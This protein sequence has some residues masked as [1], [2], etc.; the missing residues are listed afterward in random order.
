MENKNEIVLF[1]HEEFGEVRTLMI[2]GEPWFVGKDVAH[3]LK[4]KNTKDAIS[5]HI[6]EE[7]KRIIQRSENTTFEIPPRGLTIINES[8]LYSQR[9]QQEPNAAQLHQQFAAN[10]CR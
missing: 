8:G 5:V 3:I 6:D 1:K 9:R 2:D 4:Y 10:R 7:D